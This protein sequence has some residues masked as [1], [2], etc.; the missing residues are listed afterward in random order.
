[1]VLDFLAVKEERNIQTFL[2]KCYGCGDCNGN[3][4]VCRTKENTALLANL[5]EVALCIEFAELCD[6]VAGLDVACIDE[7][8]KLATALC[9]EIAELQNAGTF[10]KLNKLSLVLFHFYISLYCIS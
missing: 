4:L 6:L 5:F 9:G 7:V 2:G 1:M 8:R 10:Q 3:A